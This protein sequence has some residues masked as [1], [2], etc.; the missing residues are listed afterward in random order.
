MR[1]RALLA[2]SVVLLTACTSYPLGMNEA[3]WLALTPAQQLE[4]RTQQAEL[5]RQKEEVRSQE[6]IALAAIDAERERADLERIDR[7][8]ASAGPGDAVECVTEGAVVDYKP[9]WHGTHPATALLVRGERRE[10][11]L[12]P[13]DGH[14]KEKAVWFWFSAE[15]M[16]AALCL[17]EPKSA[18][19]LGSDCFVVAG[20]S[21]DFAR[22]VETVVPQSDWFIGRFRC[23]SDFGRGYGRTNHP[24]RH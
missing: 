8:R 5:S 3:E 24:R 21:G 14:Q 7:L 11:V 16:Q 17:S 23:Q 10:I 18:V 19:R 4:A 13:S 2:C 12:R 22:G 20:T 6:R 15:G 1:L 9:G